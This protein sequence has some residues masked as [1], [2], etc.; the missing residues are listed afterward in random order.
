MCG[1]QACYN[2]PD[3]PLQIALTESYNFL[4]PLIHLIG[5][6]WNRRH[7][8]RHLAFMGEHE[9]GEFPM[10]K[11]NTMFFSQFKLINYYLGKKLT[12]EDGRTQ[13]KR[14]HT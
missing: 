14:W 8:H 1:A 7:L 4:S 2:V 11:G 6:L 9:W 10:I 3:L 13:V 5:Q 12:R